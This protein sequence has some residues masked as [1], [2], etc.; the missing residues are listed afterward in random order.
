MNWAALYK[1]IPG[2][3]VAVVV[4][5]LVFAACA[6]VKAIARGAAETHKRGVILQDGA[7]WQRRGARLRKS[8][9]ALLTLAGIPVPFP[10]ET[11]HFKMWNS[12]PAASYRRATTL[13]RASGAATPAHS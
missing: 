9:H 11:K 8:N 6:C 10:D 2:S 7:A 4:V 3:E 12:W 13:P 1:S 5:G